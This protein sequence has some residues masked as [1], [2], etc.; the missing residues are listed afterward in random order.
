MRRDPLCRG[1]SHGARYGVV[2]LR[3]AAWRGG[4]RSDGASARA[5]TVAG[6]CILRS[7][8]SRSRPA[9]IARAAPARPPHVRAPHVRAPHVRAPLA[10]RFVALLK[11][12]VGIERR[13]RVSPACVRTSRHTK[14]QRAGLRAKRTGRIPAYT[15]RQGTTLAS[16]SAGDLG[17]KGKHKVPCGSKQPAAAL[18]NL[19]HT[20]LA[21]ALQ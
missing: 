3:A 10:G 2:A 14:P 5:L 18:Q 21:E 19:P 12:C 20:E 1:T 7:V 16:S 17:T 6:V 9:C 4:W 13:R 15:P 8:Q 11:T